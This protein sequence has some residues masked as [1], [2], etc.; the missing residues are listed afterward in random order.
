MGAAPE[1]KLVLSIQLALHAPALF[2]SAGSRRS[3][4]GHSAARHRTS[5]RLNDRHVREARRA[6]R[7]PRSGQSARS[8]RRAWTVRLHCIRRAQ[9]NDQRFFTDCVGFIFA[10]KRSN[11]RIV[12]A[13]AHAGDFLKRFGG[14]NLPLQLNANASA[15]GGQYLEMNRSLFAVHHALP[16]F[17][18]MN[19]SL[20]EFATTRMVDELCRSALIMTEMPLAAPRI[21]PTELIATTSAKF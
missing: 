18:F 16:S 8:N 1:E 14:S 7:A 15:N 11:A 13:G 20:S 17:G 9:S 3:A 21:R 12:A 5:R 4:G 6:V 10:Q 2:I 19:I